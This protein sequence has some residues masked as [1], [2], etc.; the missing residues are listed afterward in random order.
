MGR[1]EWRT[2]KSNLNQAVYI[3]KGTR[4]VV[5]NSVIAEYPQGA[6]MVCNKT[7]P[8]L[9]ET[10]LSEFKYNLV[11]SD[12]ASRTFSWDQ[13]DKV[14][15]DPELKAF[16]LNSS[17]NNTMYI[18]SAELQ[19][20]GMYATGSPDLT[21]A[22]GSPALTGANFDGTNF[23]GFFQH[24]AYRGAFGADNWAAAGNWVN[25]K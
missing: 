22:A 2:T 24:V 8:I 11:H 6:L 9:L 15:G 7:R 25:W 10:N 4:F 12:S 19:L 21:P 23:T 16:A 18:T 13:N 1:R 14:V 5:Q 3:R 20:K 17:N